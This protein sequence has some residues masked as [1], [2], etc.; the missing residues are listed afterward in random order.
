ML[1]FI[2]PSIPTFSF[3]RTLSLTLLIF[4][5]MLKPL[6]YF[7]LMDLDFFIYSLTGLSV[8]LSTGLSNSTLSS[9]HQ[10]KHREHDWPAIYPTAVPVLGQ[11]RWTSFAC[12]LTKS[13]EL[14]LSP[15][16]SCVFGD[17][18]VG[19]CHSSNQ[20]FRNVCF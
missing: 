13:V 20:F 19:F 5:S 11:F 17:F 12:Y 10:K 9:C 18:S 1:V 6:L 15:N 4:S 8:I 7:S 3:L 2:Y 16:G 14:L